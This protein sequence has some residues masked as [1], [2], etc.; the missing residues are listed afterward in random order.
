MSQMDM[1]ALTFFSW[2]VMSTEGWSCLVVEVVALV[3]GSVEVGSGDW[4]TG[5]WLTGGDGPAGGWLTG[6]VAS[7][8]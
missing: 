3:A 5:G 2:A 8:G 1:S 7:G 4:S 6:G